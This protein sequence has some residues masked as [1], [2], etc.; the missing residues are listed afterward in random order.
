MDYLHWNPVKHGLVTQVGDWPWSSFHRLVR[1]GIY[2]ADW[3]AADDI[4]GVFGE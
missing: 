3:G 2:P 1:E 4:E